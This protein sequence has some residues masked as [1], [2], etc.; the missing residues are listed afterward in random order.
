[1]DLR[2]ATAQTQ[3]MARHL[4]RNAVPASGGPYH[5]SGTGGAGPSES[6]RTVVPP[7][8]EGRGGAPNRAQRRVGVVPLRRFL[9]R[10]RSGADWCVG[11]GVQVATGATQHGMAWCPNCPKRVR[12]AASPLARYRIIGE[13]TP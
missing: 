6:A 1:M 11:S 13:H 12:T 7:L 9:A 5:R 3:R 2:T 8:A 10:L 4:A